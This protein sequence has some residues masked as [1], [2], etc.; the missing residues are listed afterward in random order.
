MQR[1]YQP[2]YDAAIMSE[3]V[4]DMMAWLRNKNLKC[5]Q[6]VGLYFWVGMTHQQIGQMA[7]GKEGA[8]TR[9]R[10]TQILCQGMSM[11][12]ARYGTAEMRHIAVQSLAGRNKKRQTKAAAANATA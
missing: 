5:Y 3:S 4:S 2:D 1:S 11:L 10:V 7:W 6:V 12:R 9:R 8:I